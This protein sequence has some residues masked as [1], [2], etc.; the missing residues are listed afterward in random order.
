[1]KIPALVPL[2]IL[3]I[4]AAIPCAAAELHP[5]NFSAGDLTGWNDEIFKGK[6]AYTLVKADGRTV[7]KAHSSRAASGLIKKVKLDAETYPVL[8]W[9]WKVEHTLKR[10]DV[11][12]KSGDDFA[13]RIYIVFPRTFFWQTRTIVYV[14]AASLPRD[15]WAFSPYT[16]RAA[17]VAVETGDGKAGQWVSEERNYCEDYRKIFGEEPPD[18]GAIAIMTDT[19]DTRDEVTAYYGDIFLKS[20]K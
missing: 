13:A 8:A 15:S 9:S 12:R 14:W 4:I 7:V 10:E 2:L 20:A 17:I 1:L 16:S 11:T 19:D 3:L 6:T 18:P 5:G